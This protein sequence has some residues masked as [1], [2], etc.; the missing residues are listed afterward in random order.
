M[1]RLGL[2]LAAVV[3]LAAAAGCGYRTT[4][5]F[6]ESVT[7]VA[8]ESFANRTFYPDLGAKLAEALSKRIQQR[9][10]Y[11]LAPPDRADAVLTGTIRAVEQREVSRRRIGAVPEEVAMTVKLDFAWR[12]AEGGEQLAERRGLTVVGHYLP[13]RPIGEPREV[14]ERDVVRTTAHRIVAAMRGAW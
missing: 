13:S 6:P 12:R 2:A 10:P 7:T 3:S 1:I 11:R 5:T 14:G 9:T 4:A 8:V